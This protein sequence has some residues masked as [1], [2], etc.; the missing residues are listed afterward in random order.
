MLLSVRGNTISWGLTFCPQD[1]VF[2][3]DTIYNIQYDKAIIK[4]RK[5]DEHE[6]YYVI[7]QKRLS[8]MPHDEELP[9]DAQHLFR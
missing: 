7:Y 9:E 5:R 2:L 6:Q 3:F 4:N 1:M 8:T